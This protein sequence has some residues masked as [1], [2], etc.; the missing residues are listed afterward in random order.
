MYCLSGGTSLDGLLCTDH[1][2]V[3]FVLSFSCVFVTA[4]RLHIV[5][6]NLNF[7]LFV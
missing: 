6:L 1:G 7:F 5:L 3:S 2:A 4:G